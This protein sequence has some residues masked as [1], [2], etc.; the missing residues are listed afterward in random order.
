MIKYVMT[1]ILNMSNR[2]FN[3]FFQYYLFVIRFTDYIYIYKYDFIY[4]D[5]AK[6]INMKWNKRKKKFVRKWLKELSFIKFLYEEM[7]I[8]LSNI[9]KNTIQHIYIYIFFRNTFI[10]IL[11]FQGWQVCSLSWKW[12]INKVFNK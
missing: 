4:K 10:N 12:Q 9:K 11:V 1:Y 6:I 8:I 7:Y 2:F 3:D 5:I